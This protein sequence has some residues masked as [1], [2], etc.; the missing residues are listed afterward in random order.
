MHYRHTPCTS[1]P[2]SDFA[3][4]SAHDSTAG[5]PSAVGAGVQ[6]WTHTRAHCGKWRH[7]K[8]SSCKWHLPLGK[9]AAPANRGEVLAVPLGTEGGVTLLQLLPYL[10]L[11]QKET[12]HC[13]LSACLWVWLSMINPNTAIFKEVTLLSLYIVFSLLPSW[14]VMCGLCWCSIVFTIYPMTS[15]KME[16]ISSL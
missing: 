5:E 6:T 3:N 15:L 16:V 4:A 12:I 14:L 9:A 7:V 13:C 2:H 10:W 1:N 11:E 8:P